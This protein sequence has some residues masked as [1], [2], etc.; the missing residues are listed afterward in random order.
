MVV[1]GSVQ[2]LANESFDLAFRV[3]LVI[4]FGALSWGRGRPNKCHDIFR[5]LSRDSAS[6]ATY[7]NSSMTLSPCIIKSHVDILSDLS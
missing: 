1:G 4:C 3:E 6:N 5:Q 7:D 2:V